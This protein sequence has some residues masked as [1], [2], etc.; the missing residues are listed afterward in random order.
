[1]TLTGNVVAQPQA[2]AEVR[3]G[4]RGGANNLRLSNIMTAPESGG[5]VSFLIDAV[6]IECG[7]SWDLSPQVGLDD[8]YICNDEGQH[9]NTFMGS[10]KVRRVTVSADGSENNSVPVGETHRFNAVDEDYIDTVN[11]LPVPLPT[12]EADPLFIAWEPFAGNY[13]K[14]EE[15]GDRQLMRFHSLGLN[16]NYSKIHGAILTALLQPLFLDT[17]GT[18]KAVRKYGIE[19]L[20]ASNPMDAPLIKRTQFEARQ[21]VWENDE[22]IEPGASYIRWTPL[23]V[24]ASEW[25]F[26]LVPVEIA[27]ES[28]DPAI[29]RISLVI[30]DLVNEDLDF[31]EVVHRFFEEIIEETFDT[32]DEPPYEWV[33]PIEESL[34]LESLSEGNRGVLPFLEETFEFEDL[35]VDEGI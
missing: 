19:A 23:A 24:D 2:W 18:I 13:L 12:P 25:G 5:S 32:A 10:V 9:N 30:E 22:T 31:S 4:N 14:I 27:P 7:G 29:A 17:P 33:F 21:F 8:V 16:D 26:E 28:Y 11:N 35:V 3:L 1:M 20:I 15:Y 6:R 34:I